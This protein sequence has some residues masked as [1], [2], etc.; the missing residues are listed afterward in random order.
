MDIIAKLIEQLASEDEIVRVQAGEFLIQMGSAAVRPLIEALQNP[1]YSARPL[2]ASTLGQIG[3]RRAV[4][5]L[6]QTLKDQDKLVRYHAALALGKLKDR[7]AVKPLIYALFDEM[8]PIGPDPLTGDQM[9][10]RSAAALA[11]GELKASEAVPALKVLLKDENQSVRRSAI[12]A[13]GQIGTREAIRALKDAV[14]QE[15]DEALLELI[16][17]MLVR[18]PYDESIETLRQ[19]AQ[20]HPKDRL[21][22]IARSF[23]QEVKLDSTAVS[24][25]PSSPPLKVRHP[26]WLLFGTVIAILLAAIFRLGWK[27]NRYAT[28]AFTGAIAALAFGF[29]KLIRSNR[30]THQLSSPEETLQAPVNMGETH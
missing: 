3:D 26:F 24:V 14:W 6:I 30:S 13:L 17:R 9:T 18:N 23:L 12:L 1:R 2:V 29:W 16:T 25:K 11:L 20:S 7:R 5:P 27:Q 22:Q 28:F 15:S 19:I 4:E 10:V 8:P 21:R